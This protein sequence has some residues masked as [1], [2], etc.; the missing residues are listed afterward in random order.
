VSNL[1]DLYALQAVLRSHGL[2]PI[3]TVR[4]S[5]F[6]WERIRREVSMPPS[7]GRL[8]QTL[9]LYPS[10]GAID[11]VLDDRLLGT[12]TRCAP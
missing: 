3:T 9:R 10:E 4:V 1:S 11:V 8:R 2:E 5:R 12:Q 6:L 7:V